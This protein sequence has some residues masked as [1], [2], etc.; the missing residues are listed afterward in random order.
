MNSVDGLMSAVKDVCSKMDHQ[1][2]QGDQ[3]IKQLEEVQDLTSDRLNTIALNQKN[4]SIEQ[5]N[6]LEVEIEKQTDQ[7]MKIQRQFESSIQSIFQANRNL[8]QE[9]KGDINVSIQR[10]NESTSEIV[11]MTS[12]WI[13]ENKE[14][15]AKAIESINKSM[16][17]AAF[18]QKKSIADINSQIEKLAGSLNEINQYYDNRTNKLH[19]ATFAIDKK[20]K[21]F[22]IMTVVGILVI[23]LLVVLL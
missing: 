20:V 4:I 18:E 7:L 15:N 21:L 3:F 19:E 14:L 6:N 2:G 11:H 10:L 17:K 16:N 8:S 9:V 5:M 12:S 1:I 13:S 22:G 23:G